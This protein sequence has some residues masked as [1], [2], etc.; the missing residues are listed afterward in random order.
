MSMVGFYENELDKLNKVIE[1]R[2]TTIEGLGQENTELEK[3]FYDVRGEA[4]A[5]RAILRSKNRELY[6]ILTDVTE[7]RNVPVSDLNESI[8]IIENRMSELVLR[9]IAKY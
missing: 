9:D 7:L 3:S 6:R 5:L 8:A 4:E 1:D 2:D